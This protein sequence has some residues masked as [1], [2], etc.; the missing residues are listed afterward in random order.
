M[1]CYKLLP[2][3][4]HPILSHQIWDW[5]QDATLICES[6][7]ER[8]SRGKYQADANPIDI[9]IY[10]SLREKSSKEPLSRPDD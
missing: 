4:H 5:L 3:H 8:L 7:K 9:G 10:S 2:Y 6:S 1:F